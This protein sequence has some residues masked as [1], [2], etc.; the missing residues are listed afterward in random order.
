[1]LPRRCPTA[2]PT[3]SIPHVPRL[4]LTISSPV[5]RSSACSP[6]AQPLCR[7]EPKMRTE[8]RRPCQQANAKS[9]SLLTHALFPSPSLSNSQ[10][11]EC[12][13]FGYL[14]A[15]TC[16]KKEEKQKRCDGDVLG[17]EHAD[18]RRDNARDARAAGV[19]RYC[20][21][22][23]VIT[24]LLLTSVPRPT[25]SVSTPAIAEHQAPITRNHKLAASR[26]LIHDSPGPRSSS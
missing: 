22:W 5:G 6:T 11:G 26:L 8:P 10:H 19:C 24:F 25:G 1:M 7:R 18:I 12:C 9:R 17:D 15:N 13:R 4:L 16:S 21:M 20:A 14:L 3:G 23:L 2:A